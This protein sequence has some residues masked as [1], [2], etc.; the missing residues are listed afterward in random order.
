MSCIQPQVSR[1]NRELRPALRVFAT[2]CVVLACSVILV[3][4]ELGVRYLSAPFVPEQAQ[5]PY[6]PLRPD[7]RVA[8]WARSTFDLQSLL[9]PAPI[10]AGYG[11]AVDR[12]HEYGPHWDGFAER[13]GT[14][15]LQVSV[16]N[17]IEAGLGAAWGEDPRYYRT[18]HQPF[19]RRVL[20]VI[21][22]TFRA[23]G[24]DGERHVAYARL[25]GDVGGAFLA[26]TWLPPSISD[27]QSAVVRSLVGLGSRAAGNA[28]R[29]FLPDVVSW[30]RHKH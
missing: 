1:D 24:S 11:T 5:K 9:I 17:G 10:T 29:E 7:Q 25:T 4:Q 21:D 18:L 26:N 8:W 2:S 22:L 16:N 13:Y 14:R 15:M 20:N 28:T 30:L 23:Y 19:K 3:G 27:W 6:V 12:P